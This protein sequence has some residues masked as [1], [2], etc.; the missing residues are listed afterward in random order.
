MKIKALAVIATL[1]I[2]AVLMAQWAGGCPWGPGFGRHW[3]FGGGF[4]T[5]ITLILIIGIGAFLFTKYIKNNT[6]SIG[7]NNDPI[8]IL[9]ARYARGEITKEDFETIKKAIS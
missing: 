2:P 6:V 4:I 7:K 5:W 1:F 3:G 8:S 9:K